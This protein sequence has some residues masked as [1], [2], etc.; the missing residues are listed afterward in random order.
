MNVVYDIYAPGT[1]NY[2]Y[3]SL[4]LI[5]IDRNFYRSPE[6]L[7]CHLLEIAGGLGRWARE[8]AMHSAEAREYLIK[9]LSWWMALVGKI[10]F[11]QAE[12]LVWLKFPRVCPYC[13]GPQCA[14]IGCKPPRPPGSGE[15]P[16]V[17]KWDRLVDIGTNVPR[18]QRP[19]TLGEWQAMFRSIYPMN[20]GQAPQ[21]VYTRLCEELGELGEA[22]RLREISQ[23]YFVN[24]AVDVFAWMVA[25]ANQLEASDPE[26]VSFLDGH[27]SSLFENGCPECEE[28]LCK[29]DP[30]LPNRAGRIAKE[31]SPNVFATLQ[32]VLLTPSEYLDVFGRRMEVVRRRG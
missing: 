11:A 1:L 8:P 31:V 22:L 26:G 23:A 30:I 19:R 7:L 32:H 13:L 9:A 15:Q 20:Q 10:G 4:N 18:D 21:Y 27:F 2:W 24:E 16:R 5:Y 25:V 17:P 29:C 6:S 28:E 12:D 3:R 14:G